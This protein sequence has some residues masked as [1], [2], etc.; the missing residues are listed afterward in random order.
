M[1]AKVRS[2]ELTEILWAND[3]LRKKFVYEAGNNTVYVSIDNITQILDAYGLQLKLTRDG[4]W[5]QI[6][7]AGVQEV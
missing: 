1:L 4:E 3:R 5:L 7:T 2:H 6:E